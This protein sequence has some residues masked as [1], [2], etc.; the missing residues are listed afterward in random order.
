MSAG[1]TRDSAPRPAPGVRLQH[2]R[3]RGTTVVLAPERVFEP[4][5]VAADVL[6]RLDGTRRVADLAAE[7]AAEYDADAATIE[8]DVLALLDDLVDK[9]VVTP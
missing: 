9:G 7:L 2:S 5:A 6:T 8:R 3:A 4:D 1:L